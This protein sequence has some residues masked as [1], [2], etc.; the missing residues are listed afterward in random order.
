MAGRKA[1]EAHSKLHI[2]KS[3]IFS[4]FLSV[5]WYFHLAVYLRAILEVANLWASMSSGR[6]SSL[7][8]RLPWSYLV[9]LLQV[10]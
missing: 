4:Q 2:F 10:F 1:L 7:I 8:L 6:R 9:F 3:C 5:L